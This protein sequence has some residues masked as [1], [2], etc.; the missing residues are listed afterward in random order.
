[1]ATTPDDLPKILYRYRSLEGNGMDRLR[2]I[3]SDRQI[4][5]SNPAAFNDP[6]DCRPVFSMDASEQEQLQYFYGV[7]KRQAPNQSRSARLAEVSRLL[8]SPNS[9]VLPEAVRGFSEYYYRYIAGG[10]GLLCVTA[11]PDDILMWSHY[12][13]SHRGVCLG[14]RAEST[15]FNTALKVRYEESRP[16]I[17]PVFQNPDEM[18]ERALLT[19]ASHWEYEKEWRL[20]RYKAGA[21]KY[22]F[23][24]NALAEVILGSQIGEAE[25]TEVRKMAASSKSNPKI[26][27][28]ALCHET[29]RIRLLED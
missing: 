18:L 10:V 29:F 9:P 8:Q 6:F 27:R 1:M 25:A 23:H 4:Y 28:A 16:V 17:N 20:I 24:S 14:F 26:R 12:A 11:S 13:S 19:K 15:S 7:Y 22:S 21:G 2:E 5:F 3:V